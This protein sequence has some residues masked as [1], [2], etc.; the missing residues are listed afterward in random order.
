MS[1]KIVRNRRPISACAKSEFRR[2]SRINSAA[3]AIVETMEDR[4][5]LTVLVGWDVNSIPSATA[6]GGGYG[7][8]PYA[9]AVTDSSVTGVVG[10]TRGAGVTTINT[11]GASAWGGNDF[12]ST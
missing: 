5:L 8:S 7:A 9:P 10:L 6:A 1:S 3:R 2:R 12:L 4:R 11:G